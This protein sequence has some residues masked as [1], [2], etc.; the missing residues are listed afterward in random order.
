MLI[1]APFSLFSADHQRK[2]VYAK[3]FDDNHV[4]SDNSLPVIVV[5]PPKIADHNFNSAVFSLK[6]GDRY[7]DSNAEYFDSVGDDE[8]FFFCIDE[9]YLE[10]VSL[11]LKYGKSDCQGFV[12]A[13]SIENFG[14]VLTK[15]KV[16]SVPSKYNPIDGQD[17][18]NC[19]N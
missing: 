9:S 6:E 11:Y 10:H 1:I 12:Y 5:A 14:E 4:C 16:Y 2:H 8:G 19:R 7:L 15:E 13:F 3:V 18:K 17:E